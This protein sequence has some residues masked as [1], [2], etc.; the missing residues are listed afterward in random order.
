[1]LG[2]GFADLLGSAD[3]GALGKAEGDD[4]GL[5]VGARLAEAIGEVEATAPALGPDAPLQAISADP[6][7]TIAVTLRA[8]GMRFM[9]PVGTQTEVLALAPPYWSV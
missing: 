2:R 3:S 9:V 7:A 1:M 5:A 8:V 4:E 6:K